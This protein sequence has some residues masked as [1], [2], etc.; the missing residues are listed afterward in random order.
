MSIIS[1]SERAAA[2]AAEGEAG[3][4]A[5]AGAH[6]DDR[7]RAAHHDD[8]THRATAAIGAAGVARAAALCDLDHFAGVGSAERRHRHGMGG[9]KTGDGEEGGGKNGFHRS[10]P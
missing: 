1:H 4:A 3:A 9:A 5:A 10:L 8:A 2:A 7:R 6:H